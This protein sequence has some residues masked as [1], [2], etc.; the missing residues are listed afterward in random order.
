MSRMQELVEALGGG[1]AE[2]AHKDPEEQAKEKPGYAGV[3]TDK[4]PIKF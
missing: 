1:A 4:S 3:E 2:R